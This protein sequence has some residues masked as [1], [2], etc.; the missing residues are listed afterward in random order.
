MLNCTPGF[1]FS[2]ATN[3]RCETKVQWINQD[4]KHV[5]KKKYVTSLK[6][7]GVVISVKNIKYQSQ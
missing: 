7:P 6:Q 4:H 5:I 2:E 3:C 1:K